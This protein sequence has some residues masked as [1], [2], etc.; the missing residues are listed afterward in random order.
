MRVRTGSRVGR[1]QAPGGLVPDVTRPCPAVPVRGRLHP[2]PGYVRGRPRSAGGR[3]QQPRGLPALTRPR[4]RNTMPRWLP[5][6]GLLC[7]WN[8]LLPAGDL[9]VLTPET[10]GGPPRQMLTRYLKR[11]AH[12]A[13]AR[14]RLAY[15][16]AKSPGRLPPSR[17]GRAVP[18]PPGK[19]P[20]RPP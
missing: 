18:G 19:R 14:R 8:P 15:E 12:D 11:L 5:T 20:F 9:K 4:R 13:L 1:R 3:P 16:A 6:L 2:L 10:A 7:L 17:K